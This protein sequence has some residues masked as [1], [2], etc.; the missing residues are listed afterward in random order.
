MQIHTQDEL[1]Q[2][3]EGRVH[4]KAHSPRQD[5]VTSKPSI[6]CFQ[7]FQVKIQVTYKSNCWYM[8]EQ[9]IKSLVELGQ[10]R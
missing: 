1:F 4:V 2:V 10:V 9:D 7:A 8:H 5:Q 3:H 6:S